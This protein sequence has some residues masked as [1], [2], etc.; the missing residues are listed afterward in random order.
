[1]KQ[2]LGDIYGAQG[3]LDSEDP[4]PEGGLGKR[5]RAAASNR[6]CLSQEESLGS[7]NMCPYPCLRGSEVWTLVLHAVCSVSCSSSRL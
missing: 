5:D 1:M 6:P 3:A 7:P 4:K 2:R